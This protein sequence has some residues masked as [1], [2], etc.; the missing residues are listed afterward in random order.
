[1]DWS[2]VSFTPHPDCKL[3]A[4]L[5]SSVLKIGLVRSGVL[6]L[7]M[8]WMGGR[9]FAVRY[10]VFEMGKKGVKVCEMGIA[11]SAGTEFRRR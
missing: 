5:C 4:L 8:G 6:G 10:G 3:K 9:Y 11:P 7:G 1:M 2:L